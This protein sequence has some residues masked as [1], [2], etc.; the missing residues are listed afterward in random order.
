MDRDRLE[1]AAKKVTGRIK[2]AVGRAV[3]DGKI[4]ADGKA[5]RAEGAVQNTIGGV[6]DTVR[7]IVRG[8]E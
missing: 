7:E 4:E 3:G 5:E 6:K 1:G 2:E 8:K